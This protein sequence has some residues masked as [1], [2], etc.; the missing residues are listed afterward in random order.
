MLSRQGLF[1]NIIMN[2]KIRVNSKLLKWLTLGG[3]G[4][5][6]LTG[7]TIVIIPAEL[8]SGNYTTCEVDLGLVEKTVKANGVVEPENEVLLNSPASSTIKKIIHE[9]GSH[10]K[11]GQV[12]LIL[13]QE[14]IKRQID[15]L[16]DQIKIKRNSLTKLNLRVKSTKLD[17]DYKEETKKLN[18][19]SIKSELVDQEKL[20]EVGGISQAKYEKTK[21]ALV[22]AE[23]ELNMTQTKN[24]IALQQLKADKEGLELE[25]EIQEKKLGSLQTTLSKMY[26]RAPSD[27]IILN[28]SKRE[29][30][31]IRE[32]ELLA[33]ISN[34]STFKIKAEID[35]E[36]VDFLKTGK[37][38]YAL[39]D[40]EK[41]PGKVGNIKPVIQDAKLHF[42]VYIDSS[43][44]PKLIANQKIDLLL[45]KHRRD[46]VLR[47]R[48]WPE[49]TKG[50]RQTLYKVENSKAVATE[51]KTGFTGDNY[52]WIKEGVEVGDLI[53]TSDVSAFR[54]AKIIELK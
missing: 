28:I 52:I 1:N 15:N 31:K 25:I 49:F 40:N 6:A 33:D 35:E 12:I 9:P 44:H 2:S 24:K 47:V 51:V 20:L 23:K 4:I 7:I 41:L 53:I 39:I 17:L 10:I 50:N 34:L 48:K 18:V 26:F 45:V 11:A 54:R 38:V 42:D 32:G 30:E 46:S 19:A 14:P 37:Q 8:K 3:I 29:G 5:L 36:H 16:E 27:G 43:N 13:D 21:Q 22:S